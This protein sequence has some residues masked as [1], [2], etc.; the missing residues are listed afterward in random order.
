MFSV[1]FGELTP[2][3][4]EQ[5]RKLQRRL[6]VHYMTGNHQRESN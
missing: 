2:R 4:A 6:Q 3:G 1:K 5:L